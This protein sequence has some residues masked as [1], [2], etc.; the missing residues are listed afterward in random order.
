MSNIYVDGGRKFE[1]V[2]FANRPDGIKNLALVLC[3][4]VRFENKCTGI[5][6]KLLCEFPNFSTAGPNF[7]DSKKD[8]PTL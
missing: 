2:S 3:V 7:R 6:R 4:L 8:A 1:G 5:A